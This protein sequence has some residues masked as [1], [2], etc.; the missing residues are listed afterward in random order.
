[1][2]ADAKALYRE[3]SLSPGILLLLFE[4]CEQHKRGETCRHKEVVDARLPRCR[5]GL[6][7]ARLEQQCN[8]VLAAGTSEPGLDAL[9]R[10][11]AVFDRGE[12]R[13][14]HWNRL[15]GLSPGRQ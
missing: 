2:E 6:L 11:R 14:K 12:A 1:M 3:C 10:H 7:L 5:D 8:L 13:L 15:A 9:N 4:V